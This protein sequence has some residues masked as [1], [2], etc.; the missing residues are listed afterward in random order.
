MRKNDNLTIESSDAG[1]TSIFAVLKTFTILGFI[2]ICVCGF[3]F[4]K[5]IK[6]NFESK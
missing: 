3:E 6:S 2:S 1:S 5:V 4:L